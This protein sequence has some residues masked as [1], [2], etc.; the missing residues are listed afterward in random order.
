[1]P[2]YIEITLERRQVRCVAEMLDAQAPRTCATV[3]DALPQGGDFGF[4]Y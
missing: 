1:M 4:F 2:R 3:W